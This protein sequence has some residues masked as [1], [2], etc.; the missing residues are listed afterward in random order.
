MLDH[1][2][3]RRLLHDD[4]DMV[5]RFLSGLEELALRIA[6]RQYRLPREDAEDILMQVLRKLWEHEKAA[7]QAWKGQGS[8]RAY[9]AAIIHRFCLMELRRRKR[10]AVEGSSDSLDA[11][12]AI[13]GPDPLEKNELEQLCRNAA[14]SLPERDRRLLQMRFVEE[15]E[16]SAITAELCISYGAARKAVYTAVSRLRERLRELAPELFH[17]DVAS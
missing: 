6:R 14:S 15:L 17:S 3:H 8:L 5:E 13:A 11:F 16:Y 1:I 2:D 7:L 4:P 12:E 10:R 9:L